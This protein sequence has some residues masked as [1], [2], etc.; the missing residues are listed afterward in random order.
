VLGTFGK[1]PSAGV[2]TKIEKSIYYNTLE[3]G[4]FELYERFVRSVG[5][6]PHSAE[7][8]KTLLTNFDVSK[9][10]KLEVKKF[11]GHPSLFIQ[12]GN[13]RLSIL[14]FKNLLP[15]G[16]PLD[17][18]EIKYCDYTRREIGEVLKSTT[19]DSI[20]KGWNNNRTPY[21]YHSFNISNIM[22]KGQ[23]NPSARLE[24]IR[25]VFCPHCRCRCV[26]E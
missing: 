7:V 18:L 15:A 16:I 25:K 12:G 21:G 24:K 3:T 5:Q 10:E 14:K 2:F 17:R 19:G 1:G 20:V 8:Y 11:I 9:I 13:H 26:S 6:D 22:F 4:N 23:R